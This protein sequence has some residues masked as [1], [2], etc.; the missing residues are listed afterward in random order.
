[1][2]TREAKDECGMLFIWRNSSEEA[3]P[4]HDTCAKVSVPH[5]LAN[6]LCAGQILR[7]EVLRPC[8]CS[9]QVRHACSELELRCISCDGNA[10]DPVLDVAM[11]DVP[12]AAFRSFHKLRCICVGC[13]SAFATE[14][15]DHS[16]GIFCSMLVGDTPQDW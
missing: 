9:L 12:L 4:I 6:L 7:L 5:K 3:I 13:P 8:K 15:L 10:M 11:L 16:H 14:R 2:K 1:M